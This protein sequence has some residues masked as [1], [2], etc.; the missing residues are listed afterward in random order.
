MAT[1]RYA[2]GYRSLGR[3]DLPRRLALEVLVEVL[4]EGA[5]ANIAVTK[6]LRTARSTHTIDARD[7][8][9]ISELVH[10]TLRALGRID[11]VLGRH[12][13]RPLHELDPMVVDLLRLGAHQV[14]HMRVPDHAAVSATVD[15]AR[16]VLT[17]GPAKFVNAVMRS[18]TR[19]DSREREEALE[20]IEDQNER[21]SV[22][23]SHPEWMVT[24]FA[25]A[26]DCHSGAVNELEDLLAA[27]N[28]API[29]TL[30]ARPTL[31]DP[32]IL[33]DEVHEVLGSRVA[34]GM[35]SPYALLIESG[36][37]ARLPSIRECL[38]GAQDEGSQVAALLAA[39]AP[40]S[41]D[42]DQNW[43]DLCAGPGGKTALM[44]ALGVSR[45]AQVL[46]NE[47]HPHRARLVEKSVRALRNVNVV[48]AD[49]R[50]FGGLGTS[51][52]LA[53]FDRV[54]VD[55]PCSG[56]G[57]LR[58]RP[59]SRWRRQPSDLDEL[60]PLQ[61]ALLERAIGL[62]RKG[63]VI[64]YVTCSPHVAETREQIEHALSHAP[65]ELLDTAA[66][67]RTCVVSDAPPLEG[68]EG[69]GGDGSTLQLWEHRHGSDLMF[70]ACLRKV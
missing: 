26:L 29:V 55:V 66:I 44:A 21:L 45:G 11:W 5:Y 58:R 12:V 41:G 9:F 61:R 3:A 33:A 39:T 15:L 23:H 27:N 69:P 64:T 52:P 59:E 4:R 30:V 22:K 20:A 10:G 36:D 56:M 40:L 1:Q 18:L 37:P 54:L 16:E 67:A 65:V 50:S 25:Q 24:A 14:L 17:D 47:V 70:M 63:G 62:T 51:W 28:E 60:L 31:V 43:L 19:E 35:L 13:N 32:S 8:A 38:A 2:Q 48:C 53:H 34:S 49:G 42:R 68:T 57:S 46:A 7:A 6:T